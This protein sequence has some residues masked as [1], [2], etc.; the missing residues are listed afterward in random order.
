MPA[1]PYDPNNHE[2]LQALPEARR[3]IFEGRYKEAND[4]VGVKMMAHPI[5]QMPYE[6]VGD[7]ILRY[8]ANERCKSQNP[9]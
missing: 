7:R 3:L 5:K 8:R 9:F 2:A 4:L 6:F 1:G